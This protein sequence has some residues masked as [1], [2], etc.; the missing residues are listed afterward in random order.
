[1]FTDQT[2]LREAFSGLFGGAV[3]VFS[4][5]V[6]PEN[7]TMSTCDPVSSEQFN[8]I[9]FPSQIVLFQIRE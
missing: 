1:M 5:L 6:T 7:K 3:P 2:L 8:Q 4:W 9:I